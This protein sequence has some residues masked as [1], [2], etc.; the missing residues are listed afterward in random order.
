MHVNGNEN[1]AEILTRG[2]QK[3]EKGTHRIDLHQ[4]LLDGE[5]KKKIFAMSTKQKM[6]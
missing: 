5:K 3:N 6:G 2:R 1:T 4:F